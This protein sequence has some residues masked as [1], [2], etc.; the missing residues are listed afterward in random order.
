MIYSILILG[1]C[2]E[3]FIIMCIRQR[4]ELQLKVIDGEHWE[5]HEGSIM[6]KK[7]QYD[8][9]R[10]TSQVFIVYKIQCARTPYVILLALKMKPSRHHPAPK[11]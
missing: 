11:N 5:L 3:T 4:F 2:M 1:H 8:N 7:D 9:L 6:R 10:N